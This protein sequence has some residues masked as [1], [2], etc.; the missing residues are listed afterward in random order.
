MI[1][2][3]SK[4]PVTKERYRDV[5]EVFKFTAFC[6]EDDTKK[7]Y[8]KLFHREATIEIR[9]PN[10]WII[11]LGGPISYRVQ[12]L[13]EI[14]PRDEWLFCIDAFGRNHGVDGKSVYVHVDVMRTLINIAREKAKVKYAN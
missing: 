11:H 4:I 14:P 3:A 9:G 7:V 13:I 8:H 5:E 1:N 6:F 10:D 12:N 2:F